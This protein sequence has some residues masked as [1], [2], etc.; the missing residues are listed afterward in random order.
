MLCRI[1]LH[2]HYI[3]IT[4]FS[5]IFNLACFFAWLCYVPESALL[6]LPCNCPTKIPQD[7]FPSSPTVAQM[8]VA[9]RSAVL[10]QPDE[11]LP[12]SPAT[13]QSS[14]STVRPPKPQA[15]SFADR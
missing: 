8:L 10:A 13:L 11:S 4:W 15:L 7:R 14:C 2:L 6:E 5:N 1:T 12:R 3:R 9:L